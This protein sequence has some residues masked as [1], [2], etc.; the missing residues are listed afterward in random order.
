MYVCMPLLVVRNFCTFLF[1]KKKKTD[2]S[3][4]VFDL[5]EYVV[6]SEFYQNTFA[7]VA[8]GLIKTGDLEGK[9]P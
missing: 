7:M 5:H 8:C 3:T 6:E 4:H 2:F 9:Y 1:F